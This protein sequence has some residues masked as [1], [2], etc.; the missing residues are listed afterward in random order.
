MAHIRIL[1]ATLNGA[2]YLPDQLASIAR[3]SHGDWSLRVGDDGSRDETRALVD[4]FARAH[5]DHDIRLLDSP[6]RGSAANFLSLAARPL[7]EGC[8]LAFS[9]QDDIWMEDRL[10][11]AVGQLGQAPDGPVPGAGKVYAS[12]T[13]LTDAAGTPL[14]PSRRHRRPPVFANAL[15]Q[16]ILAGNTLVADPAAAR[17]LERTSPAAL[18]GAGV[19]HH[20]W[21]IYQIATG[22]GARIVLDDRPGLYYRQHGHNAMAAHRGLR[23]H[24]SRLAMIRDGNYGGWIDRNLAALE[25]VADEL[26]A[27]NRELLE[28]FIRW[29]RAKTRPA[30]RPALRRLG[31]HRQSRSGDLALALMARLGRI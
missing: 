8:W 29:G 26:T 30:R 10:A 20:D 1:M 15:V 17:L 4:R 2:R 23:Q 21:W 24:L 28:Q 19:A 18:A 25:A 9:D 13:I 22:A 31:I 5:P 6:G 11:R 3:Q 14:T 27:E 16:N 12:R 7:P